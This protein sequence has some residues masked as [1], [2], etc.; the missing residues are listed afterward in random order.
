[1]KSELERAQKPRASSLHKLWRQSSATALAIAE[2][3]ANAHRFTRD[4][5][6]LD[7]RIHTQG[8]IAT[9]LPRGRIFDGLPCESQHRSLPTAVLSKPQLLSHLWQ[10]LWNDHRCVVCLL[11]RVH[12]RGL[13]GIRCNHIGRWMHSAVR[14]C[15]DVGRVLPFTGFVDAAGFDGRM[16]TEEFGSTLMLSVPA[17]SLPSKFTL[18]P[19]QAWT[20][21]SPIT[22]EMMVMLASSARMKCE[23]FGFASMRPT[24]RLLFPS[25]ARPPSRCPPKHQHRQ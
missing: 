5:S 8:M 15:R 20:T 6:R 1:M 19:L 13:G 11:R 10:N 25:A 16:R 2:A 22:P 4:T 18:P 9:K 23:M 14:H 12:C 3:A 24:V 21:A 17:M 7:P